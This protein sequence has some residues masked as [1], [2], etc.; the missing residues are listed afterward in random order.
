MRMLILLLL[1]I[2]PYTQAMEE[3]TDL[4]TCK[5]KFPQT[6]A[7]LLI[8]KEH[9]ILASIKLESIK[10]GLHTL[11]TKNTTIISP[12]FFKESHSAFIRSPSPLGQQ[13]TISS[14]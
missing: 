11:E 10:Y 6:L 2:A 14:Y 12:V 9:R 5:P 7:K 8:A 3:Q 4:N 1:C 13:Q